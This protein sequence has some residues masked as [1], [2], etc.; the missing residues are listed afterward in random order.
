M[1]LGN[2]HGYAASGHNYKLCIQC[3]YYSADILVHQCHGFMSLVT[4]QVESI[5]A[6]DARASEALCGR[7]AKR[8][9]PK[10]LRA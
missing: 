10:P 6:S 1:E 4:G 5:A 7:D 2:S 8:F 9:H 3:S